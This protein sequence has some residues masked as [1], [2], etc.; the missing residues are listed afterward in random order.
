MKDP[1]LTHELILWDLLTNNIVNFDTPEPRLGM[2]IHINSIPLIFHPG[3]WNFVPTVE[4]KGCF[5]D[6]NTVNTHLN[7]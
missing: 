4:I 2:F 7:A 5:S 6:I 3:V 1:V